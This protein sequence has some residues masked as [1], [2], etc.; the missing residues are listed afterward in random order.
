MLKR[1]ITYENPFTDEKV[2]ETHYFHI[3]KS[4]LVEMEL[5][6][7][8][9]TYTKDGVELTG[10]QAKLQRIMDSEDGRS[11]MDEIKDFI[12]RSYGIKD[13]ERFRKSKEISDDFASSEAFSQLFFELCTDPTV[14]GEF[15]SG[16]IPSNL[17][18]VAEEIRQQAEKIAAG[19]EAQEQAKEAAA[20]AEEAT[21][22]PEG[23]TDDRGTQ[24]AAATPER[25]VVLTAAE[26]QSMEHEQLKAGIADGRYKFS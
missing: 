10:A 17:P 21:P 13:G 22:Q 15:M 26:I 9:A 24:I 2:T 8:N 11:I 4:D 7:H 16:I 23:A 1:D 14:A 6:E 19:R 18:Q 12:R 5:E 25:P 3:S 20:P